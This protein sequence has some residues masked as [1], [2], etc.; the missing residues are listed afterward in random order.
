MK[1]ILPSIKIKNGAKIQ[2]GRQKELLGLFFVAGT[3]GGLQL[4]REQ[5]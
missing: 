2:D 3:L 1:Q 5:A 4:S